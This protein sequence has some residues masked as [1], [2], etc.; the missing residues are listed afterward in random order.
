M[1]RDVSANLIYRADAEFADGTRYQIRAWEVPASSEYPE[2]VKYRFQ[3]MDAD[4][5]TLLRY[6]NSHERAGVGMHHRH[7]PDGVEGIEFEGL[8]AHVRRFKQEIQ[9]R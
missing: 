1:G 3:Y 7:T 5:S 8:A 9:Q 4:G 2:G 6:D